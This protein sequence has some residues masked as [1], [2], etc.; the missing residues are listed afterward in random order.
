M[1]RAQ[2]WGLDLI[3]ASSIVFLGVFSFY[4]FSINL[5]DEGQEKIIQLT[6]EGNLIA[7]NI[8][9]DGFPQDWNKTNVVNIGLVSQDKINET[10]LDRFIQLAAQDYAKTKKIFR[11][12]HDYMILFPENITVGQ[13]E[14]LEE[15]NITNIAKISRLVIFRNKPAT[16]YIYV[17]EEE[18]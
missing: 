15:I 11:I 5:S 13:S 6:S 12:S 1:K 14:S 8:L 16:I 10:K 9:S 3:I 7:N 18:E 2:V 17:W 4:V